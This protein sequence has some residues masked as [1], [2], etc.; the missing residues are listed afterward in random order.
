MAADQ[1]NM[2]LFT[3]VDDSGVSWNKRGELD[4]VRN[5]VDGSTAAG[6]NPNWG[7]ESRRHSVRKAIYQDA[8]TFRTKTCIIYTAAAFAALVPGTDSLSFHVEGET[9]AVLYNLI[10]KIG[11][12]QPGAG[13]SSHLIDHA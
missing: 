11:E 7:R 13:G 4:A 3:Y 1:K 10:K 9:T 6:G 5:A 8:S 12:R 2:G